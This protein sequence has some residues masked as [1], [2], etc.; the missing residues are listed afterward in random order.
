MN[1]FTKLERA[2]TQLILDHPFVASILARRTMIARKDIPTMGI[3]KRGQ[4]YYNEDWVENLSVPQLVFAL[5]HETLH[6]AMQ[7]FS[8]VGERNKQ[9]WNIAGDAVI[10]DTLINASI[11]EFIT[12]GVN[13][14][15][16]KDKSTE[17]VYAS[18]PDPPNGG[19]GASKGIGG[20]GDDLLD[21]GS[22]MSD[23]EQKE[24]EA[25]VRVEVAEAMQAAKARGK[26][27]GVLEKFATDIIN[28]K[29]PWYDILERFMVSFTAGETSWKRPNRRYNHCYLPAVGKVAR[30]GKI[31][32]LTDISGSISQP[33]IMHYNGH[34]KRIIE[35]CMPEG[36]YLAYCDTSVQHEDEYG[37]EELDDVQVKFYS[38]GGTDMVAGLDH[39]AETGHELDVVVVL[40]DGYT[41]F[42]TGKHY[43]WPVIWCISS[44]VTA[45]EECG[46][47]V[48]FEMERVH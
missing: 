7:H 1:K 34:M 44:D 3:D 45:P 31:G 47:T 17:D 2:K 43:P 36:V 33:E 35:M 22:P 5:A 46:E 11:G 27:P 8:R 13:M 26:L 20:T 25:R 19:K 42:P 9:K 15:G 39:M 28:V 48:H 10:N 30:M 24:I 21:E 40:T 18:L 37:S 23:A 12:E 14:P 29:T 38:G 4:I 41:P 16:S 32:M 6:V